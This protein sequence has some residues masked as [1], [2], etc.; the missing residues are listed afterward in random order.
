MIFK[1]VAAK[2]AAKGCKKFAANRYDIH[3][4]ALQ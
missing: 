1:T 3:G 4:G 2:F